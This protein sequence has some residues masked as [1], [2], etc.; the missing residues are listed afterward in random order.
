MNQAQTLSHT[1]SFNKNDKCGFWSATRKRIFQSTFMVKLLN[2]E[3]WDFNVVYASVAVLHLWQSIKARSF[4]YFSASNPGLENAGFIGE[5]KSSIME[6]IPSDVQPKW[7]LVDGFDF[8]KVL[9]KIRQNEI[10]FPL[11]AKPNIGERGQG[12]AKINNESELRAYFEGINVPFLIQGFVE[13]PLELGVFYFRIPGEARGKVSSIVAKE[14]LELKGDGYSTLAELVEANPRARFVSEFLSKKHVSIWNTVLKRSERVRLEDIGNHC[15]GTTF[16]NDNERITP[17][18]E[19]VIDKL[20]KQIPGFYFGRYDLRATSYEAL[21]RGEF[22][23]LELNGAGAEPAHIY[24]PGFSFWEGQKV[25][26]HHWKVLYKISM[27]NKAKGEKFW[28]LKE[29][30]VVKKEHKKMLSMIGVHL[31]QAPPSLPKGEEQYIKET[32]N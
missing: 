10:T 17:E 21:E 23:I 8:E 2:W 13:G 9:N 30:T 28:N 12:V 5:R 4:F 18:L 25:L 7:F 20:S 11:I 1:M 31:A 6:L 14:F 26:L 16:I 15:R 3:Y 32:T 22:Q 24:Q 19:K 27:A 29:A